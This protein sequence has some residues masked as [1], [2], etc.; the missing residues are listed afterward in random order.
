[1][2][3][4]FRATDD[5]NV[6]IYSPLRNSIVQLS[7]FNLTKQQEWSKVKTNILKQQLRTGNIKMYEALNFIRLLGHLLINTKISK[8]LAIFAI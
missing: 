1:M 5:D 2:T 3:D 6:G 7:L 8:L 4:N